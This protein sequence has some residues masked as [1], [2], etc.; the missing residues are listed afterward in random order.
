ML[1]I[2]RT[3]PTNQIFNVQMR[4]FVHGSFLLDININILL[5]LF[6]KFF[7]T[8]KK[9]E[10]TKVNFLFVGQKVLFYK[11]TRIFLF[12]GFVTPTSELFIFK[13]SPSYRRFGRR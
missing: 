9:G 4:N 8:N 2:L 12:R 3:F 1:K 5:N 11:E 6:N 10:E 7:F 13:G